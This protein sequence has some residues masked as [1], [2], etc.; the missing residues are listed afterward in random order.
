[1]KYLLLLTLSFSKFNKSVSLVPLQNT[2][3]QEEIPNPYIELK[4][5]RIPTLNPTVFTYCVYL[6]GS[7]V[8][9]FV[10]LI[11]NWYWCGL[12]RIKEPS[13]SAQKVPENTCHYRYDQFIWRNQRRNED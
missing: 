4:R 7:I 8:L 2:Y 5:F 6:L 11:R 12:Q 9:A 3:E 13:N 1:M 10:F